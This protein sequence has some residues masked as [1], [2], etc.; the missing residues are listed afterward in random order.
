MASLAEKRMMTRYQ[1]YGNVAYAP[2]D[3]GGPVH[4]PLEEEI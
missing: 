1:S 4:V 2:Q 3:A